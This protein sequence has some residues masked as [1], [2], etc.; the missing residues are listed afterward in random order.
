MIISNHGYRSLG[1]N[2]KKRKLVLSPSRSD[3]VVQSSRFDVLVGNREIYK[4]T[5]VSGSVPK[6]KKEKV[7]LTYFFLGGGT[8]TEKK[9]NVGR[10]H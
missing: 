3:L 4:L 7:G 1:G 10:N 8:T 6:E 5:M 9:R 2:H